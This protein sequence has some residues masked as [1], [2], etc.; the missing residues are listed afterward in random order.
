MLT[1]AK[2]TTAALV[3]FATS[4]AWQVPENKPTPAPAAPPLRLLLSNLTPDATMA[5]AGAGQFAVT[6]DGVWVSNRAAGTLTRIDPKTNAM[7]T[8]IVVGKEPCFTVLSAFKS[9]W[10]PLC[11]GP[12]LAR[13][14]IP[15]STESAA[16]GTKPAPPK[17]PVVISVGIRS[18]GPIVTGTSS[19]WMITDTAGTLARIDPDTNAIVA[20]ITVPAG[21]SAMAF[22][23]N[24]VWITSESKDILTRINGSTNVVTEHIKIGRGPSAVAVGDG[25]V[26]TLNA[27]DGSVSRVDPKTNKVT[28]TIKTGVTGKGGSI[29]VGEG[30]VWVSALGMPL[31][32]LDP[33]TNRMVQQFSGPGGGALAVGL[34]SLWISATS[35][36]IWRV[37]P[38]R[39]EATRR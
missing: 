20:E 7:G 22:G 5:F 38:R 11:G 17:P 1:A 6:P 33:V 9:L 16:A 3:A 26:W 4:I 36:A 34:K 21:S 32:R 12:G 13:V 30:S 29:A 23:E 18:A 10:A 37:D 24:S 27:G 2:W 39:V 14:D 35:T 19:I 8:P 31:T 15:S 25:A 28:T